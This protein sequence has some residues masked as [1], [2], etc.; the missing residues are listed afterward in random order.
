MELR[1]VIAGQLQST[2]QRVLKSLENL[3]EDEVQRSPTGILSPIIWQV[4]HLAWTESFYAGR[5]DRPGS[6]PES[7]QQLFTSGTGGKGD[8]PVLTEVSA[9]FEKAQETLTALARSADLAHP[10]E[11]RNYSNV[12]ELLLFASA[13]REYHRGKIATLRALLGKPLGSPVR[14]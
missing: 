6:A 2:Y 14:R 5:A 4:G 13:H 10:L 7:Y 12:G 8:Y 11:G 1:D 3:T 9:A